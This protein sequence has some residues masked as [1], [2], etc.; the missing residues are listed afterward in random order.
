MLIWD[1]RGLKLVHALAYFNYFLI[2]PFVFVPT[3]FC[4]FQ[5]QTFCVHLRSCTLYN[6]NP[7]YTVTNLRADLELTE[8]ILTIRYSFHKKYCLEREFLV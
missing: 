5:K 1:V 4:R 3:F 7:L 6:V 2:D 8:S